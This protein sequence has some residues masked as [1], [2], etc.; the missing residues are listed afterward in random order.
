M[1]DDWGIP[2][3]L[4]MLG[5][6]VGYATLVSLVSRRRLARY[7]GRSCTGRLW[8]RRY[9]D[10]TKAEIRQFLQLFIDAF[11]FKPARM[12]KFGPDDRAMDVYRAQN[13]PIEISDSMELE[14]LA[15]DLEK[16]YGFDVWDVWTPDI[17]LGHL[18]EIARESQGHGAGA[19]GAR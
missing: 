8:R 15:I 19:V 3:V 11:A 7:W 13:P 10:A 14:T 9:P 6:G 2:C 4:L 5:L 17:T 18:F 16:V 12:L 1:P